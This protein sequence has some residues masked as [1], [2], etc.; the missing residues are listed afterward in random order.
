MYR[1]CIVDDQLCDLQTRDHNAVDVFMLSLFQ[2][3]YLSHSDRA[4]LLPSVLDQSHQG[5]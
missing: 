3:S 5:Q 1:N 4:D 2:S